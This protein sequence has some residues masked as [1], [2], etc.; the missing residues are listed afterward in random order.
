MDRRVGASSVFLAGGN[1]LSS[2]RIAAIAAAAILSVFPV[3]GQRVIDPKARPKPGYSVEMKQGPLAGGPIPIEKEPGD[4]IIVQPDGTIIATSRARTFR[5]PVTNRMLPRVAVAYRVVNGRVQ[6]EYTIS[7][8]LGAD[9]ISSFSLGITGPADPIVPDPWQALPIQR[10]DEAPS[11]GFMRV[12]PD[13][14]ER[15]KLNAS[16]TLPPIRIMSDLAPGLIDT[17][18]YPVPFAMSP[19]AVANGVKAG[20]F[21]SGSSPWIQQRI[22]ELD[23]PDRH[24]LKSLTI[25][26]VIALQADSWQAVRQ[27]IEA[28][29]QRPQLSWLRDHIMKAALPSDQAALGAW[30]QDL[31]KRSPAGI[32]SDF[33][34]A[35]L[36]RLRQPR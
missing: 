2:H 19:A 27:E 30:L 22:L 7:N 31:Q 16:V 18:F 3:A 29:A 15:R 4:K 1:A 28:A 23:T 9:S 32:V 20:D 8:G 11:L 6:Y 24:R 34:D 17:T 13:N 21:F 25:G 14:D 10:L 33:V 35:M 5:F 26:P 36:W 12:A